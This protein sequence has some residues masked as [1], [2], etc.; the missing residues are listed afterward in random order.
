MSIRNQCWCKLQTDSLR[1][2]LLQVRDTFT[3]SVQSFWPIEPENMGTVT[4][5][6]PLITGTPSLSVT[7]MAWR[8][9]TL[10]EDKRYI[11]QTSQSPVVGS[12]YDLQHWPLQL[13]IQVPP[14]ILHKRNTRWSTFWTVDLINSELTTF[15]QQHSSTEEQKKNIWDVG[16]SVII[17]YSGFAH[18]RLTS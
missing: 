8:P 16:Q 17:I 15:D 11:N 1:V 2:Q 3:C 6:V 14:Q 7:T 13:F 12:F 10:E 18:S 4:V 5:P 9:S